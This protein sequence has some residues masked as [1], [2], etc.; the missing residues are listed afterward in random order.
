MELIIKIIITG[1]VAAV[2]VALLN[3]WQKRGE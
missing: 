1:V 2:I 3:E